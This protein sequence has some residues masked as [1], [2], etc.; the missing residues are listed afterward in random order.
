MTI[1]HHNNNI[2]CRDPKLKYV[3]CEEKT[4]KVDAILKVKT[5]VP[6]LEPT[7][8]GKCEYVVCS[9]E[10]YKV[11]AFLKFK[12]LGPEIEKEKPCPEDSYSKSFS[13]K[14]AHHYA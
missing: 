13:A 3:V 14:K 12:L 8:C 4:K 1:S 5:L 10:V 11:P 7:E 9:K 6:K 2:A